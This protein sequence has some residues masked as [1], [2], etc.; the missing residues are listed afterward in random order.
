MRIA[1][2]HELDYGGGRRAVNDLAKEIKKS[3]LVDLYIVDDEINKDEGKFFTNVLL[4]EFIPKK[5][6]GKDWKTRLYKDTI[7]LYKLYKLHKK[8]A[9]DINSGNYDFIFVHP[10]KFT[11][12]PFILQ[13][14]KKK[15]IYYCQEPLRIVYD[16]KVASVD[17]IPIFKRQYERLNRIIR[18]YIDK[19]NILRAHNIL[20][21]SKYSQNAV[22][23]AYARESCVFYLGVNIHI[24]KPLAI[25]KQYDILF[26]GNKNVRSGYQLLSGAVKLLKVKPKICLKLREES[27]I[28]DNDLVQLYN[29]SRIVIAAAQNEPFGLIPLE[30]MACAVPVIAVNEGGYRETVVNGKTGYLIKRDAEVLADA[31]R[32]LLG[33]SRKAFELGENGRKN[34][35]QYWSWEKR[36]TELIRL[37]KA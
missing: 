31:I 3:H 10:S 9:Q 2:F 4:Y 26:I 22:K 1:I 15:T 18:K 30:A 7:E 16:P 23:D 37:F 33:N 21:N 11:Q 32:K 20:V 35:L 27:Y 6:K 5:R 12:A 14:L 19:K 17:N 29:K 24:F 34:V 36:T 25:Q 28:K 8:I 13:F